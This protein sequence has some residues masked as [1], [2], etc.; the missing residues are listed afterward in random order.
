MTLP[1]LKDFQSKRHTDFTPVC[2]FHLRASNTLV[3]CHLTCAL[4]GRGA[5]VKR[6][7]AVQGG[8]TTIGSDELVTVE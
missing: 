6:Y 4:T 7:V 3:A 8:T 1:L 5:S 2:P